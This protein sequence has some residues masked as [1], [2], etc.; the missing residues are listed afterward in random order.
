MSSV[1]LFFPETSVFRALVLV[2]ME[3]EVRRDGVTSISRRKERGLG[4]SF[5]I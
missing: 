2:E 1:N 4:R 5:H 3:S